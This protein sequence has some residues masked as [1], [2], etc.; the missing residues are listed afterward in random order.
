VLPS[1]VRFPDLPGALH[2]R[3]ALVGLA[4]GHLIRFPLNVL[5]ISSEHFVQYG[6]GPSGSGGNRDPGLCYHFK[7]LVNIFTERTGWHE[8]FIEEKAKREGGAGPPAANS[9]G[10]AVPI[11]SKKEGRKRDE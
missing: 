9:P 7:L 10:T 4:Q 5:W 3:A 8:N 11:E 6:A 2:G 1:I